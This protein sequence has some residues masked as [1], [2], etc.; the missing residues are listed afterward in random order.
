MAV[1]GQPFLNSSPVRLRAIADRPPG[2]R[3]SNRVWG[4]P[5]QPGGLLFGE[6]FSH[7]LGHSNP[8][9]PAKLRRNGP[10]TLGGDGWG[11]HFLPV[12]LHDPREMEL[13]LRKTAGSQNGHHAQYLPR[14]VRTG[15]ATFSRF[16]RSARRVPTTP[17]GNLKMGILYNWPR[18]R[19]SR[20]GHF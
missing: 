12:C 14:S 5:T 15:V 11:R 17:S 7:K 1:V 13:T 2:P 19:T 4:P 9:H 20:W 8:Q 3:E 16:Y 18:R 6:R 10:S